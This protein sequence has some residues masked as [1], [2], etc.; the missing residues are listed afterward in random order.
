MILKKKKAQCLWLIDY[1]NVSK[2]DLAYVDT[3]YSVVRQ[4]NKKIAFIRKNILGIL[5]VVCRLW[6]SSVIV[7]NT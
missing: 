6:V 7:N 5:E 4:Q 1:L 3:V 2:L